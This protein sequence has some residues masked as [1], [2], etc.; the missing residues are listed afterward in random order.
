MISDF[1]E[2]SPSQFRA[3]PGGT[4]LQRYLRGLLDY[5]MTQSGF[6]GSDMEWWHYE[7]KG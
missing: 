6:N 5:A 7:Y 3:F 4:D 2:L 1:D